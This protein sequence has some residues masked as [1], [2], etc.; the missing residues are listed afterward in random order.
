MFGCVWMRGCW[1]VFAHMLWPNSPADACLM[2]M[3]RNNHQNDPRAFSFMASHTS[4]IQSSCRLAGACA[5]RHTHSLSPCFPRRELLSLMDRLR[6]C[7]LHFWFFISPLLIPFGYWMPPNMTTCYIYH[8]RACAQSL[9]IV[10]WW[11][12]STQCCHGLQFKK[13]EKEALWCIFLV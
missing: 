2:V 11:D 5:H 9:Y 3:F 6:S 1:C 12:T 10:Q 7:L 8:W 4:S 13:K